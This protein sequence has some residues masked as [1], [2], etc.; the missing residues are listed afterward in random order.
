MATDATHEAE[1][2][3]SFIS[4]TDKDLHNVY[5]RSDTGGE[6]S[7]IPLQE[8]RMLAVISQRT[9]ACIFASEYRGKAAKCADLLTPKSMK[10]HSGRSNAIGPLRLR[11]LIISEHQIQVQMNSVDSASDEVLPDLQVRLVHDKADWTNQISVTDPV[12]GSKLHITLWRTVRIPEDG[13]LYDLPAGLVNFPLVDAA[14]LRERQPQD[15]TQDVNCVLPMY[16][17]EAMYMEFEGEKYD[18]GPGYIQ[19]PYAIRPYAGGVNAISGVPIHAKS[20]TTPSSSSNPTALTRVG[21][22]E[23]N[24][25]VDLPP[26]AEQDYLVADA[27]TSDIYVKPQWLDGVAEN[28]GRVKQFVAVPFGT[29]ESIEAQKVGN[30]N[31]GGLQLEIIPSL[32][33]HRLRHH[34]GHQITI[35]TRALYLRNSPTDQVDAGALVWDFMYSYSVS[36][37][38]YCPI[39]QSYYPITGFRCDFK[40]MALEPLYPLSHYGIENHCI[41][42]IVHKLRGGGSTGPTNKRMALG[43]GGTISQNISRDMQPPGIWD[44][45]RAIRINI[46][47][48]NSLAFEDLTGVVAPPTPISFNTYKALGI[49]FFQYYM[50]DAQAV[51]GE[52]GGILSVGSFHSDS[53]TETAVVMEEG[54]QSWTTT[55][56]QCAKC[57]RCPSFRL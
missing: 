36:Q 50:E 20:S 21:T 54:G 3:S 52:F 37:Q 10:D 44:I 45:S 29:G 22:L 9:R 35:F 4:S 51:S 14:Q 40:G 15:S 47:I 38:C 18:F 28:P 1:K 13:K 27:S 12:D 23:L 33:L 16:D 41:V 39:Q 30:D 57:H 55:P 43:V 25:V 56:D 49:P 7:N 26:L 42:D 6:M 19:R 32:P 24:E 53:G 46:Q 48:I 34:Q 11:F 17:R 2:F 8:W 5:F 31:V